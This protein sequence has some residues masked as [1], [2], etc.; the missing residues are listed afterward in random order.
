MTQPTVAVIIPTFNRAP[1]LPA[2]IDS[3]IAQTAS[4]GFEI[5]VID[6]GSTDNTEQVIQPYLE[7]H[8][9]PAGK[10]IVRYTGLNKQGVVTARNTGIGQTQAPY[11]AF[12]DSDD[13][14]A[15]QK[16]EQQ[17]N[18]FEQDTQLGVVHTAFR[19]VDEDN[20]FQDDGIQRP[21]NPCVGHCVDVLLDEDLVIFSSV[22]MRRSVIEEAASAEPHGLPFDPRWTNAQDY[23]LLLRAA[24]LA[25]FA[26]IP[27]PL[28]LYR[29]HGSHGAMGNL[30]RAYGYHSQVQIDFVRRYGKEYGIT[31][32]QAKIR[33]ANFIFGRAKAAFWRRQFPI[34]KDLCRLARELEIYD[35][36]FAKLRRKMFFVARVH[37]QSQG[38]PGPISR[39]R[40]TPTVSESTGQNPIRVLFIARAPFISGAERAMM[41]MLRHLD[42]T[43]IE[44]S[45]VL[46]CES[47][48][49]N[50]AQQLN[51][52]FAVLP[53]PKRS[54]YKPISWW[55]SKRRMAQHIENFRPD[56]IHANDVPSCQAMSVV[57]ARLKIPRVVH[58][59]WVITADDAAWWARSGA[60][61]VICISQWV[62]DEFGDTAG[63]SLGHSRIE[64]LPDA[65]DWPAQNDEELPPPTNTANELVLG[66]AGQLIESK[67]L[68]LVIQAMG[69]LPQQRQPRL[70]VAGE[71]TQSA[72]AY[73]KELEELS[74]QCGV[75]DRIQWLG[76]LKDVSELYQQVTA[77]VCPSRIEPLG[78]V[79]LEAARYSL[80]TLAN[81]IGGLT[82]T[83]EQKITGY[84]IEPTV[85]SWVTALEQAH[86]MHTLA[87]MGQQAHERTKRLYSPQV[88]Q[89]KLNGIYQ[90]LIG[91]I[92]S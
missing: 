38:L 3:V 49:I 51:I 43:T 11:I 87:R 91:N 75:A 61:C 21:N 5:L 63:T 89:Q 23:D 52:P 40:K 60:E 50:Q 36:R 85:D 29:L 22:L 71:D 12:L 26:Y 45:L 72:G 88:Y 64:V 20:Q 30:Q 10:V 27:E 6:D 35:D 4:C 74:Q 46:G 25:P 13:Y 73:R 70:L 82:E 65:V 67:G 33:A 86:D 1:L 34:A 37:V 81:H 48:L 28:T 15:P 44:P 17:L 41:S 2:A 14:W 31:E 77:M 76:F 79:P 83:I 80:P 7:R 59:R 54:R 55:Q 84:L 39:Q 9:D 42:R 92:A 18:T 53:L 8:N 32:A 16:I 58:I 57:G 19:Y 69:Q 78:L 62:R 47:E 66:F 90:H 56:V 68:D 24:R